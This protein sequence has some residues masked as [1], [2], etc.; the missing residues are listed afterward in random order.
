VSEE[1]IIQRKIDH[2]I[3][4]GQLLTLAAIDPDISRYVLSQCTHIT[5]LEYQRLKLIAQQKGWL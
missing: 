2:A 1:R 4:G 5:S 3:T